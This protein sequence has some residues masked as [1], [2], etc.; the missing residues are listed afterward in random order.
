[1]LKELRKVKRELGYDRSRFPDKREIILSELLAEKGGHS[2]VDRRY[3]RASDQALED[4]I[5][6]APDDP[7]LRLLQGF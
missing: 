4:A 7:N 1:M 6:E 2:L 3:F 5:R